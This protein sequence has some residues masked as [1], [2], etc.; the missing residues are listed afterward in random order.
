M[1]MG[2][3]SK[4]KYQVLA[5]KRSDQSE[6]C[7]M[8]PIDARKFKRELRKLCRSYGLEVT[9]DRARGPG[10]HTGLIFS[11]RETGIRLTLVIPGKKEISPGVQRNALKYFADLGTRVALAEIIR[12]ILEHIIGK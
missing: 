8:V 4:N 10:S 5:V 9:E 3:P 6:E 11:D 7:A 2:R 1:G 12:R